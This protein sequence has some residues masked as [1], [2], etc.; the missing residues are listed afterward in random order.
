MSVE[1]T[2][3]KSFHITCLSGFVLKIIAIVSMTFDH[4]GYLINIFYSQYSGDTASYV[5][6]VFRT[7]GRLA[8]PL[9]CL[10]IVE[11]VMHTRSIKKYILRLSSMALII[12]IAQI[13]MEF[14]FHYS[15]Y[16][17]NIFI[18]L[19]LGALM[20]YAL[21]Q[22]NSWIKAL[23]LLPLIYGVISFVLFGYEYSTNNKIMVWWLPY[24]LRS[25]YFFLS[26]LFMLGFYFSY[27]IINFY[28]N[29]RQKEIGIDLEY[30]KTTNQYRFAVNATMVL[31]LA[32][33]TFGVYLLCAYII[34]MEYV[35]FDNACQSFALIA[36]AFILLYNGKRGYNAKWFEYGC[37]LYYPLHLVVLYAIFYLIT[38]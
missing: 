35:F 33:I 9:F 4:I 5:S 27:I 10:L 31:F 34:P 16:Q 37:Y 8:L 12:L 18:D 3:K 15:L 30:I 24:F 36:G 28:Y 25:Q 7:I 17:G 1:Q 11:G 32:M 14:G 6:E 23:A 13:I 26:F 2:E 20:I 21:K 19:T 29:S 22:K 38:M